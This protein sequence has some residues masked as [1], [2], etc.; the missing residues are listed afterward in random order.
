MCL[1]LLTFK[2]VRFETL[3]R[4]FQHKVVYEVYKY[5]SYYFSDSVVNNVVTKT[6]L[7]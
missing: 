2:T 3:V 4:N 5:T 7:V 6:V 1:V